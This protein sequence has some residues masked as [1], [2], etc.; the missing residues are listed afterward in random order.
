MKANLIEQ[1]AG[2]YLVNYLHIFGW[3]KLEICAKLVT[4]FI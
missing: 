3:T 1:I 4:S 2:G